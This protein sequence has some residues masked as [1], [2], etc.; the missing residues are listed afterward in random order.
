MRAVC[1]G[2]CVRSSMDL[3]KWGARGVG[4]L[5]GS[6]RL[7]PALSILFACFFT[8][9]LL[10]MGSC[11]VGRPTPK[12]PLAFGRNCLVPESEPVLECV[13]FFFL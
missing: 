6:R 5:K 11:S 12:V 7:V 4:F 13:L 8:L 2:V 3:G 9:L 1:I 10:V